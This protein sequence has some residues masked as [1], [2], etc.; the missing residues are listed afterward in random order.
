M[1]RINFGRIAWVFIILGV[2]SIVAAVFCAFYFSDATWGGL[3]SMPFMARYPLEQYSP[4]FFAVGLVSLALAWIVRDYALRHPMIEAEASEPPPSPRPLTIGRSRR[5]LTIAI[6]LQAIALGVIISTYAMADTNVATA[7]NDCYLHIGD[8]EVRDLILLAN[9]TME[10]PSNIDLHLNTLQARISISYGYAP[11]TYARPVG[12]INVSDQFVPAYDEVS[13]P[14]SIETSADV[15][16][17]LLAHPY[18]YDIGITTTYSVTGT[19]L[20]VTITKE[21]T[22]VINYRRL[23][24]QP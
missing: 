2:S 6:V 1:K 10:N 13:V 12:T 18:G 16:N 24:D 19:W 4:M 23:E 5:T 14:V 11:I 8:F 15:A 9:V 22:A 3:Y 7:A 21:S 20:F 17:F